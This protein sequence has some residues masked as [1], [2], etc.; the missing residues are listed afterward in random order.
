MLWGAGRKEPHV[1]SYHGNLLP[2]TVSGIWQAIGND[3]NPCWHGGKPRVCYR[4]ALHSVKASK[5]MATE[6]RTT[7]ALSAEVPK[8]RSRCTYTVPRW[9]GAGRDMETG[10]LMHYRYSLSQEALGT[11]PLTCDLEDSYLFDI[12]DQV[13][14]CVWGPMSLKMIKN[15][16]TV[17]LVRGSGWRGR[18]EQGAGR[19][20][21]GWW[22]GGLWC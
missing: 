18:R 14:Q 4:K 10:Q 21:S 3:I 20:G 5:T 8:L 13:V 19:K 9:W 22:R 15:N 7:A 16:Q 11:G 2:Q 17:L 1:V 6:G 12:P